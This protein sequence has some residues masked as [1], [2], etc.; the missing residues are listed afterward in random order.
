MTIKY[1]KGA[2]RMLSKACL[3]AAILAGSAAPAAAEKDPLR[4]D[5]PDRP[6]LSDTTSPVLYKCDNIEDCQKQAAEYCSA[7][8]YPNGRILLR[9]LP[10]SP[11]PFPVYTVIC[12][13]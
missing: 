1:F 5:A 13:E 2:G 10:S 6:L 4:I 3:G 11:R 8:N 9:E 7:F 12:F